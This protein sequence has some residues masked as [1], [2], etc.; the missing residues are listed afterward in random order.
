MNEKSKLIEEV[1]L[2]FSHRSTPSRLDLKK[3]SDF[4]LAPPLLLSLDNQ[5]MTDFLDAA[6]GLEGAQ[7]REGF[8]EGER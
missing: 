5:P 8:E 7:T 1:V 6:D 4:S 3:N 2:V